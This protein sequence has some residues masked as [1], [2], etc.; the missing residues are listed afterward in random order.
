MHI[1][2]STRACKFK[3]TLTLSCM[4]Q[5]SCQYNSKYIGATAS[6]VVA[7]SSNSESELMAAVATMGPVAVA[8]DANTYAFRV[9]MHNVQVRIGRIMWQLYFA[10]CSTIKVESLVPR[11]VLVPS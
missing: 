7:I 1:Q 2:F 9:R 10:P 5:S 11:R 3:S 4:Q 8:V 6:G